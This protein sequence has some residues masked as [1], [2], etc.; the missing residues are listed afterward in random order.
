M[1]EG[2]LSSSREKYVIKI[3]EPNSEDESSDDEVSG[4]E[5]KIVIISYCMVY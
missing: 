3:R 5:M 4:V 1:R 2:N